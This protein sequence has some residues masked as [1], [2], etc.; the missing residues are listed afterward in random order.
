MGLVQ[1]TPA[2]ASTNPLVQYFGSNG[3]GQDTQADDLLVCTIAA[4]F[5]SATGPAPIPTIGVPSTPGFTWTLAATETYQFQLAGYGGSPYVALIVAVYYIAGAAAMAATVN[6]TVA[7]TFAGGGT[8][9]GGGMQLLEASGAGAPIATTAA[10]GYFTPA[11]AGNFAIPGPAFLLCFVTD[12][13]YDSEF[14]AGSGYTLIPA[15]SEFYG[16]NQYQITFSGGSFPTAFGAAIFGGWCMVAVAFGT[17][18]SPPP[19]IPTATN[20]FTPLYPPTKKQPFTLWGLEAKRADSITADGIK[21]SVLDH[22]DTVTT[23]HFPFVAL[24]GT[25]SGEL[26]LEDGGGIELE[27][28]AGVLQLEQIL[29]DLSQWKVFEE[30]ALTGGVFT[31][32]PI[33]DYP[34]DLPGSAIEDQMFQWPGT[35]PGETGCSLVQLLSMDWTPKFKSFGIFSLDMK[36][37]LV[38]DVTGTDSGTGDILLEDGAD[39]ELESGAGVVQL[40]R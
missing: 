28:G 17:G 20:G 9:S 35:V 23:L 19:P 34:N 11:T 31:Y 12:P 15:G 30:Y 39:I 7:L 26:L 3:L 14:V 36:L 5:E 38:A 13:N 2:V 1:F 8:A 24:M 22:I 18:I 27:S 33:P 16:D 25:L 40:E 10:T 4:Y 6:T 29:G 37:L 32:N 21:Q